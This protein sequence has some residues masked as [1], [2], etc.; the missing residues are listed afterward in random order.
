VKSLPVYIYVPMNFVHAPVSARR[1]EIPVDISPP[2]NLA[3]EE[4]AVDKMLRMISTSRNPI[5]LI[6]ALAARHNATAETR[7]LVDVL[8]LSFFATPMGKAIVNE[9]HPR[10]CGIYNGAVSY[11]G[12]ADAVE[13]SDCVINIG[14]LLADSNTGGLSRKLSSEQL[15][16]LEPS[17]CEVY[18][19]E[20]LLDS[21]SNLLTD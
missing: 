3:N 15:I 4:R 9:T 13:S 8:D 19:L 5:V 7:E 1:L 6:D 17:R 18:N 20:L 11:P 14:P 21:I 12:I 2:I 10:F 16:L